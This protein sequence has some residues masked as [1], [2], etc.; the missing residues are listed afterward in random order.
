M[1]H[2]YSL[3]GYRIV[4]DTNSGA[5]HFFD[6]IPFAMLD[7]LEDSVPDSPPADMLKAFQDPHDPELVQEAYH[8]LKE[9]YA[10]EVLF[11]SDEDYGKFSVMLQDAPVKSMCLKCCS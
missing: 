7:Y 4:I 1:I 11:S 6:E 9:L 10:Q 8:E 3:G 2:K 5:V